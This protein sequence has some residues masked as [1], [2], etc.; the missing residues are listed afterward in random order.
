M[1]AWQVFTLTGACMGTV[2]MI[3]DS[4]VYDCCYKLL[5]VFQKRKV[6]GLKVLKN[7]LFFF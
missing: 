1:L 6:Y 4:T 2:K 5:R 7:I 3:V